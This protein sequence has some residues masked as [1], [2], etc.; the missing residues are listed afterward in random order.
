MRAVS[1][2]QEMIDRVNERIKKEEFVASCIKYRL[3]PECGEEAKEIIPTG[4]HQIV[5]V[6]DNPMTTGNFECESCG[7]KFRYGEYC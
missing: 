7:N 4:W 3:C 1:I 2:T 5:T 6:F